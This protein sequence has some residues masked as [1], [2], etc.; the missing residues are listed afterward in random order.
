MGIKM[1][2]KK[3]LN[4]IPAFTSEDEEREFWATHDSVDH[5][6]WG[7]ARF[8]LKP[9]TRTISLSPE[10]LAHV[11]EAAGPLALERAGAMLDERVEETPG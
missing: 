5:V 1:S 9:S 7:R 11:M 6:D 2:R 10:A 3:N 4:P 8:A